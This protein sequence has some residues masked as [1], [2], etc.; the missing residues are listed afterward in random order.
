[1]AKSRSND[2]AK[3]TKGLVQ[4]LAKT[5]PAQPLPGTQAEEPLVIPLAREEL[6]VGKRLYQSGKVVVKK[7]LQERPETVEVPLEKVSLEVKRVPINEL[8]G[9]APATRQ[10]GDTLIIPVVEEVV[11]VEKRLCLVEELHLTTRR[12]Q[13][14]HSQHIMLQHEQLSVERVEGEEVHPARS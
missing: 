3:E 11:V 13:T 12:Q 2:R 14:L 9:E 10:E 1:M 8:V 5:T 7:T 4:A 6:E